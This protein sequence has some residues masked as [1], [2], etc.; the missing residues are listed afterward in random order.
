MKLSVQ[1]L[2]DSENTERLEKV[3]K[4]LKQKEFLLKWA[5]KKTK[6]SKTYYD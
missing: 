1:K 6:E 3:K 2:E 4:K 5:Q